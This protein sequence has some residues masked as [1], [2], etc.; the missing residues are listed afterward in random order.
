[1]RS[2]DLDEISEEDLL[3]QVIEA[4]TNGDTVSLIW[5]GKEASRIVPAS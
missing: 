1:M 4:V 2:I 5:R 3:S